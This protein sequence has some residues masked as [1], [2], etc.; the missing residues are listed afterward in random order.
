MDN[1]K[2]DAYFIEKAIAEIDVIEYYIGECTYEEFLDDQVLV[3]AV[4]FRLVQMVENVKCISE[5]YKAAH[6]EIEWGEI[7]GFRNGIVHEYGQTDYAIVY[8]VVSKDVKGLKNC[9]TQN[10]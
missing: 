5:A 3:D 10:R 1:Q 8:E 4:M 7:I 6:P 2:D 9:L